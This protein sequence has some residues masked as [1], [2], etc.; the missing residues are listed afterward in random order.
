MAFRSRQTI[1]KD[2]QAARVL[3][4]RERQADELLP[5]TPPLQ[6]IPHGD[7]RGRAAGARAAGT[8]ANIDDALAQNAAP[9]PDE[10]AQNRSS[11]Q[12]RAMDR[13]ADAGEAKRS[14]GQDAVRKLANKY[15]ATTAFVG[16]NRI[17]GI[18][19]S[20]HR[21]P[22][23]RLLHWVRE[24]LQQHGITQTGRRHGHNIFG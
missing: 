11:R 16:K 18:I 2:D 20:R 24:I 6:S 5:A 21:S 13:W 8:L 15:A 3:R 10:P 1:S 9:K 23:I 4:A 12:D 7:D 22:N 19:P 14:A 17:N